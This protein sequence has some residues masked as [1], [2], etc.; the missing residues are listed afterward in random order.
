[1]DGTTAQRVTDEQRTINRPTM[2][3]NDQGRAT[4]TKD[5]GQLGGQPRTSM[6]SSML[7]LAQWP[8][9]C[10]DDNNAWR[11]QRL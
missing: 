11:M 1:M 10:G 6:M 7:A 2:T 8:S 3:R 9:R 5:Q 4:V